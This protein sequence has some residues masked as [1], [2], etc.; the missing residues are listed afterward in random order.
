[1]R[2]RPAVVLAVLAAVALIGALA[3]RSGN[4][5]AKG[6]PP[7]TTAPK[8]RPKPDPN[9]VVT[10][11]GPLPG[12]LLIA[13]RGN[14]R[15]LLVDPHRRLLWS[16]PTARDRRLGRRLVF[17]DDT[18]VQPGGKALV[19]NEE[20]NGDIVSI[21]IATHRLTRLFGVPGV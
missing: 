20:D 15:I 7:T 3:Q 2:W 19:T 6:G 21:D 9:R 4:R 10:A 13:D 14:D 8:P 1:M 11:A 16:F 17:D 5:S 18:F 12:A